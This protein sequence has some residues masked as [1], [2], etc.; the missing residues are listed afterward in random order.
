MKEEIVED[1]A[2]CGT[3]QETRAN[4]SLGAAVMRAALLC[5]RFGVGICSAT[6][7]DGMTKSVSCLLSV[8]FGLSPECGPPGRQSEQILLNDSEG[9]DCRRQGRMV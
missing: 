9:G 1:K 6:L 4:I 5:R 2:S 7:R 8:T 3:R